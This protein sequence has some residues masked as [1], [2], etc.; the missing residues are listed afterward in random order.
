MKYLRSF[1]RKIGSYLIRLSFVGEKKDIYAIKSNGSPYRLPG[2]I[3][4]AK[5]KKRQ[6]HVRRKP[7]NSRTRK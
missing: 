6:T 3:K 5:K 7:Y 4:S 2:A 1:L